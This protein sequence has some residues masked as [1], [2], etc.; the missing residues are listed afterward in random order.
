VRTS[1]PFLKEKAFQTVSDPEMNNT[2][3]TWSDRM[4]GARES[5]LDWITGAQP[6]PVLNTEERYPLPIQGRDLP[7]QMREDLDRIRADAIDTQGA[8]VDYAALRNHPAYLEFRKEL[9]P[10][11]R[12]FDPTLLSS[13]AERKAFW[14]N[15][16]HALVLDAVISFGIKQSVAEGWLGLMLFFRKAAYNVGGQRLT[17]NDIEHGILRGNAGHPLAP[18]PHFASPDRRRAWVV[19]KPDPRIHFAL[20]CASKSCPPIQVYSADKLDSQLDLATRSFLNAD[21]KI[22]PTRKIIAVSSIFRWYARDFGGREGV[23]SFL[24]NHLPSDERRDWLS[25]NRGFVRLDY[26]P[27][28]WSL[29]VTSR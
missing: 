1:Q 26:V 14:I 2:G 20:N 9:S 3:Q 6:S 24:I 15:L 21:V 11:L 27:Y 7:A 23:I 5:F 12:S 22:H 8:L 4:V 17:L 13:E 28:D 10:S 25:I 29:N 16:Y 19:N 18:G